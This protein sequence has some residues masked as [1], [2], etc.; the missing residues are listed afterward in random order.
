M[1]REL[2]T[3]L[4]VVYYRGRYWAATVWSKVGKASGGDGAP[5][6]EARGAGKAAG[7]PRRRTNPSLEPAA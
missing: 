1:A 3:D 4:K 2:T 6:T 7:K 5:E